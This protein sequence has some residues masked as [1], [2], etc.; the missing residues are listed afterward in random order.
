[1]AGPMPLQG[2]G[3][4]GFSLTREGMQCPLP[5]SWTGQLPQ[6]IEW[7]KMSFKD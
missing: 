3:E 2:D 1:M 7:D 6:G 4:V 5:P